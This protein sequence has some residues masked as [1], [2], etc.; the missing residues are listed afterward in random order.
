MQKK[1]NLGDCLK[2]YKIVLKNVLIKS[3]YSVYQLMKKKVGILDKK[4]EPVFSSRFILI[5]QL[6][7][8]TI[9]EPFMWVSRQS[10]NLEKFK[11]WQ[12]IYF[13]CSV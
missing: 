12:L 7:F 3:L 10:Y 4:L 5:G 11:I 1:L 2:F 6:T 13:T 8:R 9:K